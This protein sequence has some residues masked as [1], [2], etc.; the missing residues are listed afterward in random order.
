MTIIIVMVMMM[1]VIRM[2]MVIRM[3]MMMINIIDSIITFHNMIIIMERI[4]ILLYM[5]KVDS[6]DCTTTVLCVEG[7]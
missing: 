7:R 1:I 6:N 5:S 4:Q 2:M 3:K